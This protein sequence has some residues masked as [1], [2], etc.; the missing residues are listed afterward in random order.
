MHTHK[1][2][3]LDFCCCMHASGSMR[4]LRFYF[5]CVVCVIFESKLRHTVLDKSS[6]TFFGA[7]RM[8]RFAFSKPAWWLRR[9]IRTAPKNV[10]KLLS[11]TVSSYR[12]FDATAGDVGPCRSI[13]YHTQITHFQSRFATE[14]GSTTPELLTSRH[15]APVTIKIVF[16]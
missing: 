16:Y 7:V 2:E 8:P 1:K 12:K 9:A 6:C 15:F 13:R 11:S 5:T 3:H 14:S 10:H 4:V